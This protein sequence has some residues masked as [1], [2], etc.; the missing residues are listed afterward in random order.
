MVAGTLVAAVAAYLFQLVAGRVLGPE[1]LQPI[2][3]LWTIQ[4]LVFTIVFMP[5]EQLT[6]RRLNSAVAAAAPWRLFLWLIGAS[7]VGAVL[8]GWATL[9]RQFGGNPWFLLILAALI[10]AYGGFALGRGFLAGRRRYREY[11]LSVLAESMLRLILAIA[12]LGAGIGA[13]GVSWTLVAGAL[14]VWM[15][16]PLR[17]ER[18]REAGVAREAGSGS[19][20]ATFITANASAQ[21]LV[22]AGPL[23]VSALGG[24]A[25]AQSVF[26]ETFLLFRAPLTIAYSLIA[27]VL[28]PFTAM[29]DRGEAHILRRWAVRI[30]LAGAVLAPVAY[31][32]GRLVGADLVEL[33]LEPE[34]RP[35]AELAALAAAGT[36]LATVSLVEQQLLIAMRATRR[37]AAAWLVALLVAALVIIPDGAEPSLRVGRAFL[38]GETTALLALTAAILYRGRRRSAGS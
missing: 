12:L 36:T 18:R 2:V 11:G 37:M 23:V 24:N 4:F 8:Y 30:A 3:V 26:F 17:G 38:A 5:M 19:I 32:V 20:L 7:T 25:L 22:A 9:D 35:T 33:L 31:G 16:N 21:T 13:L 10:A 6:I 34:F 29:V 15:W 1:K 28:P 14:V 27:R